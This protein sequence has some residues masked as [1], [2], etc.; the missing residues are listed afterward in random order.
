M[1]EFKFIDR[2]YGKY[3]VKM[4]HLERNGSVHTIKEYEVST[5][6]RLDSD[7][8]YKTGDNSDIVATD[9]QKNTVYLLAKKHGVGTPE[10]FAILVA[11][12]F[13]QTY[14]WV[15][16]AEIKVEELSWNRIRGNHAH[17]FVAN[18]TVTRWAKV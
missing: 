13:V 4:L 2:G 10:Q 7:K 6:I 15:N 9:S 5:L 3:W 12:H 16:R 14:D 17:A 1:A 11:K 8:D 18:P